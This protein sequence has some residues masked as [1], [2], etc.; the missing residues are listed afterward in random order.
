MI[1]KYLPF[2]ILLIS[3]ALFSYSV[4]AKYIKA[5][6][7][8]QP[9]NGKGEIQMTLN[10]SFQMVKSMEEII[11]A[12]GISGSDVEKSQEGYASIK[13]RSLIYFVLMLT[14]IILFYIAVLEMNKNRKKYLV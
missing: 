10:E 9:K 3:V 8:I 2:L 5:E 7:T 13:S 11:A 4:Y 6:L 1:R 12:N 14:S